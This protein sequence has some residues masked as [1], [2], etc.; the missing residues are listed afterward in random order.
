MYRLLTIQ[1]L[2]SVQAA[3]HWLLNSPVDTV[4]GDV[5][6]QA[7]KQGL[8][9]YEL[10][11]NWHADGKMIAQ[12]FKAGLSRIPEE[13]VELGTLLHG[14]G[15]IDAHTHENYIKILIK[16]FR[17]W[18]PNVSLHKVLITAAEYD[19]NTLPPDRLEAIAFAHWVSSGKLESNSFR[20]AIYRTKRFHGNISTGSYGFYFVA[21]IILAIDSQVIDN[22]IETYPYQLSLSDIGSAAIWF[23]SPSGFLSQVPYLLKCRTPSIKCLAA[24]SLVCQSDYG[25]PSL[26]YGDFVKLLVEN[27][28]D[29]GDAIWMSGFWLKESIGNKRFIEQRIQQFKSRIKSY[30][31]DNNNVVG[32][33]HLVEMELCKLRNECEDAERQLPKLPS[34]LDSMITMMADAWPKDGLSDDQMIALE[35]AFVDTSEIRYY[36]ACKLKHSASRT[37]LLERNMQKLDEFIDSKNVNSNKYFQP[38]VD[39]FNMIVPWAAKSFV[40]LFTAHNRGIG[41]KTSDYVYELAIESEEILKQPFIAARQPDL[42]QSIITRAACADIFALMVVQSV[43][44]EQQNAVSELNKLAI[45]HAFKILCGPLPEQGMYNNLRVFDELA[46]RAVF[47]MSFCQNPDRFRKSWGLADD[48]SIFSRALALWSS[49]NLVEQHIDIAVA[50]FRQVSQIPL[51]IENR[52]RQLSCMLSL[53]DCAIAYCEYEG[54]FD[55][56]SLIISLWDEAYKD[57]QVISNRWANAANMFANAVKKEGTD[58]VAFLAESSFANFYCRK[59]IESRDAIGVRHI[60]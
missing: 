3:L 51:S 41:M 50:L 22:W 6:V 43:P 2:P 31:E 25:T 11:E 40:L 13:P 33:Y 47:Q 53:L 14:L 8:I 18:K 56:V 12:L 37:W 58:R 57:W 23:V 17:R 42:W 26:N 24:A 5:I 45:K 55:L 54:K 20:D 10:T 36:L 44:Q 30:E 9:S 27:G 32:N 39:Q 59:L 46:S 19:T 1:E 34:D 16:Y 52:D 4:N 7:Q 48:L 35:N 60:K 38:S 21:R 28:I 49:P 29:P 15:E